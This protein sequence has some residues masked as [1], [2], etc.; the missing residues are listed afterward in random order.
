MARSAPLWGSPP[1]LSRRRC[2]RRPTSGLRCLSFVP[3]SSHVVILAAR[4]CAARR[5]FPVTALYPPPY[6]WPSPPEKEERVLRRRQIGRAH[7]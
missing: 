2:I 1:L 6:V 7:V 4:V 5:R 3:L